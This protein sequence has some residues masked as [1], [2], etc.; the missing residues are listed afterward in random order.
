MEL[1]VKKRVV[2]TLTWAASTDIQKAL[3]REGL[4]T[5]IVFRVK[6]TMSAAFNAVAP[7]GPFRVIESFRIE[8]AGR[9]FFSL[10]GEQL[11]RLWRYLNL[12]D[13]PDVPAINEDSLDT[14]TTTF[15]VTWVFHPGSNPNDPFDLSAAIPA[16]DLSD[17]VAIWSTTANNVV[18]R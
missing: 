12:L 2:E 3:P 5:R 4:I 10:S 18:S 17:L 7:D 6:I 15:S 16:Q 9:R 14:S 1:K 8:G 11:G 13:F